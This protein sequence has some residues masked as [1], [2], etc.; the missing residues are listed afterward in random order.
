MGTPKRPVTDLSQ[1]LTRSSRAINI[2]RVAAAVAH[3]ETLTFAGRVFRADNRVA[4]P[5][6]A[7]EVAVPLFTHAGKAARALT[8]VAEENAVADETVTIASQ[9]YTFKALAAAPN[10][11]LI[12]ADSSATAANLASAINAGAGAGTAYGTGTVANASVTAAAVAN[13]VTVTAIIPGTVGNSIAIAEG[14]T[15]GSWASAATTLAGGTDASA[16]NFTT[17]LVAAIAADA[18]TEIAATRISANEVLFEDR[19]ANGHVNQACSETLAGSN[20]VWAA[21]ATFGGEIYEGI[22]DSA[23]FKRTPTA[24]E[25]TLGTMH[26]VL[27]FTASRFIVQARTAAGAAKAITSLVTV[28]GRRLTITADGAT[29]L[30][31]TDV[32][33]VLASQ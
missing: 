26:F 24:T 16:A 32:V 17:E 5:V 29:V 18:T 12:G 4:P 27:P 33:T 1:S 22:P 30:A 7:G 11:V 19:S 14:M 2:L 6:V 31:D 10:D 8:I 3:L 20:N 28:T 15:Q 21:N 25:V 13:V 23:M 9:V